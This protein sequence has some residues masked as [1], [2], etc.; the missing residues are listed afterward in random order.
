MDLDR[1]SRY[2]P[3]ILVLAIPPR[4]MRQAVGVSMR[5]DRGWRASC[6][7]GFRL[8]GLRLLAIALV[9][10]AASGCASQSGVQLASYAT[11][12]P[13]TTV[14]FETIDGPPPDVFERL[15]AALNDEASARQI[16]VVSRSG[17]ATYRVRGYMSAVIEGGKTSFGWVWDLYDADKNRTLRIA[18]E[19]PAGRSGRL[20]WSGADDQVLHR[21]ARDGMGRLAAFLGGAG[22]PPPAPAATEPVQPI[23]VSLRDD[24]PEAAGIFRVIK[25][26]ERPAAAPTAVPSGAI[27]A[28]AM[29]RSAALEARH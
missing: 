24:S 9:A 4:R 11:A 6:A 19:E 2:A 27:P 26:G 28:T 7:C 3:A 16:A 10:G 8:Y 23:L 21:M 25:G 22:D 12:S 1:E 13:S 14:A 17:P 15:V 29:T 5:W 20:A 18:G